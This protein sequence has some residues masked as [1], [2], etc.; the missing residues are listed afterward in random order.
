MKKFLDISIVLNLILV[1]QK[2]T[3]K[4]DFQIRSIFK[5]FFYIFRNNFKISSEEFV[6]FFDKSITECNLILI[7]KLC[8]FLNIIFSKYLS[9]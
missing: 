2:D 7:E 5:Y 1:N 3:Y 4:L 9:N 8:I 6:S